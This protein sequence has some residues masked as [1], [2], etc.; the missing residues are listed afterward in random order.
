[1]V[2]TEGD[3]LA[4]LVNPQPFTLA[5]CAGCETCYEQRDYRRLDQ[6]VSGKRVCRCGS[7][8][9]VSHFAVF[10]R[11]LVRPCILAGTSEKG[12][13]PA[14]GAPWKRITERVKVG[15]W[16]PDPE[17]KHDA[18]AVDGTAARAKESLPAPKTVRWE[19]SCSCTLFGGDP[20]PCVVLDPFGGSGT[21]AI[22]A[23]SLGR[24]AILIEKNP[25]YAKMADYQVKREEE[26]ALLV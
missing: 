20:E 21:T 8:E 12:R 2:D 14:C 4:L 5:M 26:A 18:G 23:V 9:W 25:R 17:H 24:H 16:H 7:T 11:R 6:D 1:M 3:P 10:P 19:P 15:D 13:C 22:E